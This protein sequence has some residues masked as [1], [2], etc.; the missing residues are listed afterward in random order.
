MKR[1]VGGGGKYLVNGG[2]LP[3]DHDSALKISNA[4]NAIETDITDNFHMFASFK[5]RITLANSYTEV[6][7]LSFNETSGIWELA[8][9][10]QEKFADVLCDPID[11]NTV[12]LYIGGWVNPSTF[13]APFKDEDGVAIVNGDTYF[14]SQTNAGK[15]TKTSMATGWEQEAF[16]RHGDKIYI[17]VQDEPTEIVAGAIASPTEAV[18]YY[19]TQGV[20]TAIPYADFLNSFKQD[21]FDKV[22]EEHVLYNGALVTAAGTVTLSDTWDNYYKLIFV[23]INSATQSGANQDETHYEFLTSFVTPSD[24]TATDGTGE[25]AFYKAG[26]SDFLLGYFRDTNRNEIQISAALN[27][28][29]LIKIIGV[30]KKT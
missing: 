26:T 30:G 20:I 6:V 21:M 24:A 12:D 18:L 3:T 16:T 23:A 15:F 7:G 28:V 19:D 2:A 27:G 9:V 29:G 5:Q 13:T 17:R 8:D 22:F 1:I 4:I 11:S 25:C 10:T 14:M